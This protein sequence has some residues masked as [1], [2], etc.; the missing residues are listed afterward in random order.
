M[1]QPYLHGSRRNI[2]CKH[3][4]PVFRIWLAAGPAWAASSLRPERDRQETLLYEFAEL[5][6]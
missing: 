3:L 5:L 4:H 6:W 2:G 1:H